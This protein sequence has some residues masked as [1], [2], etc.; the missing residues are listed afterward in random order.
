MPSIPDLERF[1]ITDP[2]KDKYAHPFLVDD[3]TSGILIADDV[4][5]VHYKPTKNRKSQ[6][7]PHHVAQKD[8]SKRIL[9]DWRTELRVTEK[10]PHYGEGFLSMSSDLQSILVR[11]LGCITA[12]K[13]RIEQLDKPTKLVHLAQYR[14]GTKRKEFEKAEIFKMME[15]LV[16]EP[17][18]TE[19]A[20]PILFAPKKNGTLQFCGNYRRLNAVTKRDSRPIPRVDEWFDS[21]DKD[22]IFSTL[23]ANSEY[24]QIDIEKSDVD[25]TSLASHRALYLFIHVQ[26][27]L[28]N[29]YVTF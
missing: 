9:E 14:T 29:A 18:Q 22:A 11:L 10:H 6:L 13:H 2:G 16:I 23:D 24:W 1:S 17:T 3:D 15:R 19:W 28:W 4:A 25:E 7:L 5:A 8:E 26:S 27:G 12:A 20:V 21:L